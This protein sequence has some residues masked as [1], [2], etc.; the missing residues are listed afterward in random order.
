MVTSPIT[1]AAGSIQVSGWMRGVR[2]GTARIIGRVGGQRGDADLAEDRPAERRV[3]AFEL[4]DVRDD[5]EVVPEDSLAHVAPRH[6]TPGDTALRRERSGRTY[7]I[8]NKPA[9][10]MPPPTHMVT[11]TRR[12]PRRLPS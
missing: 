9:A 12:A 6:S 5:G 7:A 4:R 10:P 2:P 1:S 11:T 3:G 8:S